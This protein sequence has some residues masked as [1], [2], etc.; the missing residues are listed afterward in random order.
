MEGI[1]QY[2]KSQNRQQDL[3][4]STH[5][6]KER[7]I[8]CA[9]KLT[10]AW[11]V[12]ATE[13]GCEIQGTSWANSQLQHLLQEVEVHPIK[14]IIIRCIMGH[15][16]YHMYSHCFTVIMFC[17]LLDH[18]PSSLF[19]RPYVKINMH[20]RIDIIM[21]GWWSFLWHILTQFES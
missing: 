13:R 9:G 1:N 5:H 14:T 11:F 16:P 18:I 12:T 3:A 7:R 15:V 17:V 19:S 8:Q 21:R 2:T 6:G 20:T 10:S 4:G